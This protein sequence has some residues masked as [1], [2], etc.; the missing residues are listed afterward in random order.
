[1]KPLIGVTNYYVD[2]NELGEFEERP[3]GVTGQDMQMCTMDYLTGVR[4][5]DGIPIM[6]SNITDDEYIDSIVKKC[7]GFLFSGGP[8]I[9]PL[10]YDE[11]PRKG[12]GSI[13]PQRDEFEFKLLER[14][15]KAQKPIFF[16]FF[17]F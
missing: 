3:R 15:I 10:L 17:F 5:A 7:D 6:L 11:N 8:D 12:C 16:F 13:V 4:Q 1:M 9:D 2:S 14:V